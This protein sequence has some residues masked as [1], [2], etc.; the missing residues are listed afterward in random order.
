MAYQPKS[1]KKFVA[2]AATATLVASAVVPAAFAN[3]A[4]TAAFTDVPKSYEAAI[5]FVVTNNIS[6]GLTETQYGIDKQIKRGDAAIIIANAAGLNNTDAK[7]SGFKDV[8][9][10]GALAINSLKAA[11]IVNGKTTTNFGFE[12]SITRGE[13]AI[14]LQRAFELTGDVKDVKFS[15]VG[16][17]YDEAVAALLANKV[18]QGVSSTKFGT[19]NPIKRGDFAKF[20]YALKDKVEVGAP[21]VQ[22]VTA[23]NGK[24]VAA[25]N[26]APDTAP[27]A[28]DFVVTRS[29]NGGAVETVTASNIAYDAAT[30]SVTFSVA[31][32]AQ[33]NAA[34]TVTYSVKYKDGAAKS[35][36]FTVAAAA[37]PAIQAVAAADNNT[38]TLLFNS[39]VEAANAAI[40][41]NYSLDADVS[42]SNDLPVFPTSATVGTESSGPYAGNQIVT[43]KFPDATGSGDSL[44]D[45]LQTNVEGAL[46][47]SNLKAVSGANVPTTTLEINPSATIGDAKPLV[48]AE[49]TNG[50]QSSTSLINANAGNN[51]SLKVGSSAGANVASVRYR[52]LKPDN[53][54]TSWTSVNAE[55]GRY[56][57]RA[58]T[59]VANINTTGFTGG[60]YQVQVESTD[61]AGRTT[62]TAVNKLDTLRLNI[63]ANDIT[64]PE[65]SDAT[66]GKYNSA[67]RRVEVSGTA[68]DVNNVSD[69]SNVQY[70]V[71]TYNSTTK[72][73]TTATDWT[74][75]SAADGTF[76]EKIEGF[77]F[78]TPQL[79][80]STSYRIQVRATDA[81]GNVSVPSDVAVA[82]GEATPATTFVTPAESG[83]TDAPAA[84]TFSQ[85]T[86]GGE[87]IDTGETNRT[88]KT[89]VRIAGNA[90][91]VATTGNAQV[92]NVEV[93][94][95]RDATNAEGYETTVRDYSSTGV[96]AVDGG[97]NSNDENF[98]ANFDLPSTNGDYLIAVRTVDAA[99]NKGAVRTYAV[100][101]DTT[102]PTVTAVA[103]T[104]TTDEN[105][106]YIFTFSEDVVNATPG[107][108]G[109]VSADA[110]DFDNYTIQQNGQVVTENIVTSVTPINGS[111]RQFLVTFTD[112]PTTAQTITISSVRDLAGNAIATTRFNVTQ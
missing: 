66:A 30:K 84:P 62:T 13:A 24:V 86:F 82:V 58:E 75:A 97:F 55:D 81:A 108:N 63:V 3:E 41:A 83:D 98:V 60:S 33:T 111:D 96:T 106:D 20:I 39:P 65:F 112:A 72:A 31:E 17:R 73:Y 2:T 101:V 103:N 99:G 45:A 50:A 27:V 70:R 54:Y 100:T 46:T 74:N 40:L 4:E 12:D 110:L 7:A 26:V 25:F 11:G 18:T 67:T 5:D 32:V 6:K 89:N 48:T 61:L 15:D 23:S 90:T 35:A 78:E 49:L 94:V 64:A 1:Y 29:I 91:D 85:V 52:L 47:I 56:D 51:V 107:R 109:V 92:S 88:N 34:Q 76:N 71:Q 28:G 36:S 37:V 105:A 68:G 19:Q 77:S 93:A 22:T 44:V 102:A 42:R 8:P 38:I 79:S 43:L 95:Y 10:R 87:V 104:E 16:D 59:A 69:V 53:S 80:N 21:T 57:E 14:M 9:T